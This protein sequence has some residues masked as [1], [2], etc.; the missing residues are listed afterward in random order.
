MSKVAFPNT[1]S[2]YIF[3]FRMYATSLALCPVSRTCSVVN[4]P[5]KSAASSSSGRQFGTALSFRTN[6]STF[7]KVRGTSSTTSD[8]PSAKIEIRST[9]SRRSSRTFPNSTRESRHFNLSSKNL[10]FGFYLQWLHL[11]TL[12]I[13]CYTLLLTY[14]HLCNLVLSTLFFIRM[15]FYFF[16]AISK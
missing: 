15:L 14:L 6:V 7:L 5:S 16:S 8:A 12:L 9:Q 4:W 3:H 10:K 13:P 1:L 2:V 11:C